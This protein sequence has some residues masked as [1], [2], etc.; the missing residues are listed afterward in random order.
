VLEMT[1]WG[2][3]LKAAEFVPYVMDDRFAPRFVSGRRAE[4]VLAVMRATSG[5]AHSG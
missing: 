1:F 5:P 3:E 2:A 4:Q